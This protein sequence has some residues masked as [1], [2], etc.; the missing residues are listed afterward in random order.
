MRC[1]RANALKKVRMSSPSPNPINV[2]SN[3]PNAK[4][5]SLEQVV[6]PQG[7]TRFSIPGWN[8]EGGLFLP[9]TPEFQAGE[10]FVT[11]SRTYDTW[12]EFFGGEEF[13]FCI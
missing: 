1:S 6:P 3:D 10:L 11:L 13:E 4:G 5:L 8:G 2:F 7:K 9:G 12:V